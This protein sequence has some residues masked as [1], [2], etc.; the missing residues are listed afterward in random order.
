MIKRQTPSAFA[1]IVREK[2]LQIA[3][4]ILRVDQVTQTGKRQGKRRQP[5]LPIDDLRNA[6]NTRADAD[7]RPQKIGAPLIHCINEITHQN[8]G[9]GRLPGIT[10]LIG[11]YP[12]A[13]SRLKKLEN[14]LGFGVNSQI[15]HQNFRYA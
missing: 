15:R 3:R 12:K 11:W 1:Y 5:L 13:C 10:A 7:N 8:C 6:G 4:L 9:I 2:L 14:C